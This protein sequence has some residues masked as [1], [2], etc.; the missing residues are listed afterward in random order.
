MTAFDLLLRGGLVVDGT[1]STGRIADIG[2]LGDRI[3]AIGDL[4]AV[5]DNE[6][7]TT[8]G[9]SGHVVCPG[10]IDPH[11]HSDGSLFLDGGLV[12]H[13]RQGFT[14]QLSGNCGDSLAPITDLGRE[15]VEL[16]LRPHALVA[17]WR[18]F[19]EY[20]DEVARQKLG[21]NVA[22][23][24]G[25]G[26]V[27]G[28][29]LGSDARDPDDEEF[30][31]MVDE[32][33][34]AMD[35]GAFGLSSGLIYAPG[36]HAGADEVAAL[37]IAATRRGG[38]YA[39]HMRDE[40]RGLFDSLAESIGAIRAAA[41]AG[42]AS[43]R[44][45]VSHLK[46]GSAAVWGRAV[47]AIAILESA[48]AEGLDVAADQ[49]PHTAAATSLAT[50]LPPALLSLGV[51]DALLALSDLDVRGRVQAEIAQGV[52]GWENVAADPGWGG[53]V[54]SYAGSHPEWSGL[55]LAYLGEA[56]DR[57]PADVAFDAL[58]DDHLDVSVVIHCMSEPDVEAIMAVPWIAVCT[59]AEGRRPGHPV[60]DAGKPHPR[61]YGTTA[62]VLGTYV[63]ERAALPL[64][65]AVAKMTSVPAGRLGLRDRGVLR[66][67]A[68]A[69]VVIFDPATVADVATYAEP[70][71]HP[72]G[73]QHVVVNG[74]LAVR[75][76][77]ETGERAGR[78]LRHAG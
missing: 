49:Y 35:A 22:F 18:T 14:T 11:G 75:D 55:S 67:G 62:R 26:T 58:I 41:A 19:A 46:A 28:S 66:K 7:A 59:D 61:T 39:T 76:G 10:F 77:V 53:I 6:V 64:E 4:S 71:Q 21:L 42:V 52:S 44:L 5:G 29:V 8:L 31:A 54:I 50:I 9:V 24:V 30:R 25:H 43:P 72:V 68:L 47:E 36:M 27:R 48:R 45:Q 37:V 16:S 20:L 78:L 2:I 70:A 33:E 15:L 40:T 12:S 65:A 69:D 13:L 73:I 32:V 34:Q 60:L 38:L 74:R 23:L 56:L 17:R 63:R 3:L 1:G 51:D 57:D